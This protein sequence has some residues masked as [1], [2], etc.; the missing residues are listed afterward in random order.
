M[1]YNPIILALDTP[2]DQALQLVR[3]LKE[4]V[5]AF[6][7]GS[8]LFTSAGPSIIRSIHKEG[9]RVFL[10]LKF[11]DIPN[12]VARA[13]TAAA[14]FKVWMMN[15]HASGGVAMMEAAVSAAQAVGAETGSNSLI[16]GVTVLTSFDQGVLRMLGVNNTPLE[17]VARLTFLAQRA[18]LDGLVCS[19]QEVKMVRDMVTPEIQLVVP[20][21][22]PAGAESQ[23]QKRT[24]TPKQAITDGANWLVIG[25]PIYEAKDPRRAAEE[26]FASLA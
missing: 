25:R 3:E 15:V 9:A 2:V 1:K 26:I 14:R 23:D 7:V 10:D 13:V 20:G 11:H 18:K 19:A 8:E 21:I 12:T 17:Q 22:R 6:K 16:L 5:G 24:G 4:S